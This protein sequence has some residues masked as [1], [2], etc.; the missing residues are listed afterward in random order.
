VIDCSA[1]VTMDSA[2]LGRAGLSSV[3]AMPA[4]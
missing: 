4:A 1:C 3:P 2:R